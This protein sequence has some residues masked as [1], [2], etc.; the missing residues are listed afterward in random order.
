MCWCKIVY[1]NRK[2]KI[3]KFKKIPIMHHWREYPSPSSYVMIANH[4]QNLKH[5]ELLVPGDTLH[6]DLR[7][8][9]GRRLA[10]GLSNS[11]DLGTDRED[12]P[13]QSKRSSRFLKFFFFL[14]L[15]SI[16]LFSFAVHVCT[17]CIFSFLSYFCCLVSLFSQI[18]PFLLLLCFML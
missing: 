9:V 10:G 5:T 13:L 4:P 7:S 2:H 16:L 11:G 8:T 17:Q 3:S 18:W 1:S 12:S 6:S 15:L 14:T